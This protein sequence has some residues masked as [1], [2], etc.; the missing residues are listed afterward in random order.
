MILGSF[1]RKKIKTNYETQ[2][3]KNQVLN[4]KIKN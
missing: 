3:L 1:D 4:K 2:S